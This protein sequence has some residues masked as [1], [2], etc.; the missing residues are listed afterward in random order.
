MLEEEATIQKLKTVGVF[1]EGSTSARPKGEFNP[2]FLIAEHS[3]EPTEEEFKLLEVLIKRYLA[4]MYSPRE[5]KDQFWGFGA[6]TI[7]LLKRAGIWHF[8]RNSW[9]DKSWAPPVGLEVFRL[10]STNICR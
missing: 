3:E 1:L 6:N 5:V 8:R 4:S 10:F 7:I 2:F 9:T